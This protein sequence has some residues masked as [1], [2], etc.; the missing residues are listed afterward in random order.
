MTYSVLKMLSNYLENNDEENEIYTQA[1]L[2]TVFAYTPLHELTI[3]G[4]LREGSVTS[5]H[6]R[7][8]QQLRLATTSTRNINAA[9]PASIDRRT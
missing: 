9:P 4:R 5:S 3:I 7:Q 1:H 8:Q 2:S 6:Q